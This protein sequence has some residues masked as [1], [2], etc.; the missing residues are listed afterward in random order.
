MDCGADET[1]T[2][3][4]ASQASSPEDIVATIGQGFNLNEKQWLAFQIVTDFF[5]RKHVTKVCESTERLTMLMTGPGGTGKTHVVKA[6]RAVMQHYGCGHLIR[7]LAPTG[8]AAALID[9]MT[10]HKGLGIKIR[11]SN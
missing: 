1:H 9:G 5:L 6:V 2:F 4:S 3:G 8:S 10:V 7:F 11:S